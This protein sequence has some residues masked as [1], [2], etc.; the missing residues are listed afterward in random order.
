MLSTRYPQVLTAKIFGTNEHEHE[1][2]LDIINISGR[3]MLHFV[4]MKETWQDLVLVFVMPC[5]CL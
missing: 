1:A 4:A 2:V 5:S 3:H